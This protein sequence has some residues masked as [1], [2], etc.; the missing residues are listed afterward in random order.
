MAAIYRGTSPRVL[1]AETTQATRKRGA[2]LT[3]QHAALQ[4][5]LEARGVV[6]SSHI[7]RLG[8]AL[9]VHVRR[10]QVEEIAALPGVQKIFPVRLHPRALTHSVPF[11]GGTAAWG[12]GGGRVDGRKMRIGIIDTGIDYTHADFGGSG[13]PDDYANNDPTRIETGTFPTAKVVGGFDF[14]GDDYDA[15]D[16][17]HSIPHPDPDPLDTDAG[18][19]HGTHVAGIAAGFGVLTNGQAYRGEYSNELDL[20]Q[21]KIGPGVA[22]GALLYALKVFGKT[23]STGLDLEAMEWAADPNGDYDF[24]DHLDVVNLSLGTDFGAADPDDPE[25]AAANNLSL[26]GCVVVCAGGNNG[27][28]FYGVSSP[29][30]A[31]RAISVA[32]S[33]AIA[34]GPA[35]ELLS[36]AS[37]AGKYYAPEG[38]FTAQ[39]ADFG[40]VTGR[41]VSAKPSDACDPLRNATN[42]A[43]NIALIDRGTC[44]FVEKIRKVQEA[45]AIGVIMVNNVEGDPIVMGGEAM[46]IVIPG[47]MIS[48]ADGA[49]IR[50]RLSQNP[51]ARLDGTLTLLRTQ[52]LD[53][54][55]SDSSRG[56]VGLAKLLKPE[57]AAPGSDIFSAA[58][59]EGAEGHAL[60]GTSMASPHVA[61][62][63]ALLRQA[64]PTWSVEEIKAALM[65]TAGATQN[66]QLVRYP[67]S[68]TGAGRIQI[69]RALELR[70]TA[71]ATDAD[72]NVALSFGSLVVAS[73]FQTNRSI[74][75]VNHD[76]NAVVLRIQ[77]SNTLAQVGVSLTPGTNAVTVP[78]NGSLAVPFALRANP[79]DFNLVHDLVTPLV[80]DDV[81]RQ[82]LYEA[83]GQIWFLNDRESLHVPY[84]ASVRGA[85][86]YVAETNRVVLAPELSTEQQLQLTIPIRGSSAVPG[87]MVSVFELGGTFPDQNLHSP[88]DSD[89]SLI[90]IGAA[91]DLATSGSVS[92]ANL[93]FGLAT[94]T[95]WP[96]P[97]TAYV[98]LLVYVDTN[99]DGVADYRLSNDNVSF[100]T[101]NGDAGDVFTT[102]LERLD[103][104]E[105]SISTETGG[106]LNVYTADQLDTAPFNNSVMIQSISASQIG[107]QDGR[108]AFRYRAATY[109]FFAHVSDTGWI[110]FDPARPT[111]DTAA[112]GMEGTPLYPD[113]EPI[114]VRFDRAAAADNRLRLP[115]ILLLHHHNT[116][117]KRMEVV[118]LDL[119]NDDVNQNGL[120]DWWEML[121]FENLTAA[122]QDRD[123]DGDGLSDRAEYL[124][125]TDP[126]DPGS[127][128]KILSALPQ[129]DGGIRVSWP[130]VIGKRYSVLGSP[131][132]SPATWTGLS[133]DQYATPPVNSF[134]DTNNAGDAVYFY[135]IELR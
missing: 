59:G 53:N 23:G 107:L 19:G 67:E 18:T 106:Y 125:G 30:V 97:Q 47:V 132:L 87:A 109:G 71:A 17:A 133:A 127:G 75:L 93:Y 33:I 70:T 111:F 46:D 86:D 74:L 82:A 113:G 21:F 36:P 73:V 56:P 34:T 90:A 62:A 15:G 22:P 121:Y 124:A 84:Y 39:L 38:S 65:N 80:V 120:P 5:R 42:L 6:V 66:D 77:V 76:T 100:T 50:T 118:Q 92:N 79:A 11:I 43:G 27:N 98:W 91:S 85:S 99:H 117:G 3:S 129:A 101:G 94:A 8:N 12:T 115:G 88:Y 32:N 95:S 4:S 130:S 128:L 48:Q 41:V 29:G 108:S 57:L 58:I 110:D 116:E 60:S 105:N 28:L 122:A 24:S 45:G 31:S 16:S 1:L 83:S 20:A 131:S 13:K 104:Q 64:H 114:V 123:A 61:G 126:T 7:T 96:T 26:L 10:N 68:M 25:L 35:I 102:V 51:V 135:R 89:A 81:A 69:D 119:A 49:L 78:P 103:D 134:T 54:L 14:A 44:L 9:K 37:L 72:G 63:A 2:E 40:V 52:I 55:S 112:S